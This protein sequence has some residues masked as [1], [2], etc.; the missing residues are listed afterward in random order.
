MNDNYESVTLDEWISIHSTEDE[1]RSVFLNLDRALKYI[2]EHG[3]CIEVFH[4]QFIFV[5]NNSDNYI[6]FKK[7]MELSNDSLL[8]KKMIQEDIFHSSLIQIAYYLRMSD[9]NQLNPDF[10]RENFDEVVQFL[11][12]DDS[13]Y[14]RG[15]I[16]RGASVYFCE[17]AL[18]KRNRDLE[19]L[20]KQIG[21]ESTNEKVYFKDNISITNDSVND[22]IYKQINGIKDRAF[23][24]S[25]LIPSI[26]LGM[27]LVFGVISWIFSLIG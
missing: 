6:Q 1:M 4:P 17:Y 15:V 3:Y 16:Q 2:H 13:P 24:H 11:P 5:L 23:I 14:Y 22:I 8:R 12:S 26:V 20:E 7:L 10:L 18:E 25:L 9:L 21:E 19:D 27:L